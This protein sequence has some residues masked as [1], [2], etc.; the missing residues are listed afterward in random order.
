[1][2]SMNKFKVLTVL[3]VC[4]FLFV[5][6]AIYS[7]TKDAATSKTL[8]TQKTLSTDNNQKAESA[9]SDSSVEYLETQLEILNKWVDELS[10]RGSSSSEDVNC[11]I[12]GVSTSD[13][14]L[15]LSQVAAIEEAKTNDYEIVVSCSF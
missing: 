8:P 10:Q 11:K 5:I 12:I 9:R 1:M 4:M 6:A 3:I 7:N 13:G 15:R 14:I 2:E